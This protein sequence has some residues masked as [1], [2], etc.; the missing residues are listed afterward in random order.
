MLLPNIMESD[1][2]INDWFIANKLTL[3]I[4]KTKCM[5][6]GP[7]H[8]DEYATKRVAAFFRDHIGMTNIC[9]S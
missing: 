4:N 3:N 6:I 8:F 9:A 2:K 1:L 7:K 5:F